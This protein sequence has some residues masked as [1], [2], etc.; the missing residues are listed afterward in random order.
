MRLALGEVEMQRIRKEY[1]EYL[2]NTY[3]Q[4]QVVVPL[5]GF[6]GV[7]RDNYFGEELISRTEV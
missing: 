2:Y 7:Q 5:C 3:I 6:D 4:E 1:F